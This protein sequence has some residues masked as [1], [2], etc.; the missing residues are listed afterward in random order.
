MNKLFRFL[1]LSAVLFGAAFMLSC[2]DDDPK[3][4]DIPEEIT[5]VTL[6]FTPVTS[7]G[8]ATV[9]VTATDPDQDGP[10]DIEVDGPINLARNVLYTLSIEMINEL[11]EPND[12][13]YDITEEVEEEAGEHQF[14][15]SW[16]GNIFSS[17]TGN[18]NIDNASDAVN[19]QDEDEN[20]LPLGL[21]TAWT[22]ANAAASNQQ[23]RI[24]LKHQPDIK[25][26]NTGAEDG[27]TDVDITFV[28][29]VN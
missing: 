20:G 16:T 26:A 5:K 4:E 19:Y 3:V 8:A 14:F 15:F 1:T 21:S 29:N 10:Q 11:A 28:V 27:E 24:V 6:T 25:S 22:T 13:E 17:P 7:S 9:T 18:G 12:P 2:D 23:F